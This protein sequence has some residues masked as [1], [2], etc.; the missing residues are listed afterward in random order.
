M[1]PF[2]TYVYS[3]VAEHML[4]PALPDPV[5]PY[6]TE[7]WSGRALRERGAKLFVVS[8]WYVWRSYLA[9]GKQIAVEYFER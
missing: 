2:M 4:A 5:Q 6:T 3:V 7:L 1:T 9:I 8:H